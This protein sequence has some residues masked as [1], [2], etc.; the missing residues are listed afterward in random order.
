VKNTGKPLPLA[1]RPESSMAEPVMLRLLSLL[2]LP[3]ARLRTKFLL[4]LFVVSASL[5]CA[6]LLLVQHR[7]RLQVR[8]EI[9]EALQN[10]VVTFRNFQRLREAA[11]ER[12]AS[13]LALQPLLQALMTAED[14]ATIQDSSTGWWRRTGSDVFVLADRSGRLMALHS[15]PPGLTSAE[16]QDLLARWLR[17]GQSHDWWLGGGYLFEVFIQPIYSGP[18]S[19]PM[20]RG[21]VAVGYE[22]DAR[23]AAAV[24]GVA[25]SHV[26]FRYGPA[27][28]VSTLPP[29]QQ[30]ELSLQAERQAL[31]SVWGPIDIRLGEERFVATSI[32]LAPGGPAGG[33]ISLIVLKS[34]DQATAFLNNLN[35]WLGGLGLAAILAGSALIFL[36]SSTFTRPLAGLVAGVH[37][38]ERGDFS[39]PLAV[40]GKD[41]VSELTT[42]FD[43]M[44]RTLQTAQQKLLHAERLATIGRMAST[45]S[46]DLRHP[47]TAI[48]A[49]AEFLCEAKIDEKRRSEFYLEIRQAVNQMTDQLSTLLEFS[50]ARVVY[51]PVSSDVQEVIRRAIRTVQARPEHRGIAITSRHE[52]APDAWFDPDKLQRV[53]HN[54]LLNACEAVSPESGRIEVRSQLTA[55]G[56]EIRVADNG[57][58]IPLEIRHQTFQ[59]FVTHGKEGGTGLG[60][61]VVQKIVQ[62]HGGEVRVETTGREGTVFR[63]TLPSQAPVSNDASLKY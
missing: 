28:V 52:G 24:R 14:P 3:K 26:V 32:E 13:L 15:D 27:T 44:R 33:G 48:L 46:H 40:R 6:T 12:S 41:E 53:L 2:R 18:P 21:V 50:K 25:S 23:L 51:R 45:I 58:G 36:I 30:A 22:I 34:Y 47:L 56:L 5:T 1:P 61:A 43:R 4:S 38:L 19:E 62:E 8:G 59:P 16:A 10:S 35:R 63:I 29:V 42:S 17:H 54:L 39:Y 7:V 55:Q 49:Y 20:M 9:V 11:L 37:A 60:L 57:P 31:G